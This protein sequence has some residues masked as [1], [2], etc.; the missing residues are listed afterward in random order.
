MSHHRAS[1]DQPPC[2]AK[3][4]LRFVSIKYNRTA[5]IE[6]ICQEGRSSHSQIPRARMHTESYRD[7]QEVPGPARDRNEEGRAWP[8]AVWGFS[9]KERARQGRCTE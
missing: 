8:R 5:D 6:M 3:N 4:V 2:C 7:T 9:G 1:H